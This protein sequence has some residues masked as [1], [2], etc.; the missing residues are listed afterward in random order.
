MRENWGDP[1]GM[2]PGLWFSDAEG[3]EPT[4]YPTGVS[5]ETDGTWTAIVTIDPGVVTIYY[6]M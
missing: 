1:T 5:Q 4:F 2:T 6:Y 3:S